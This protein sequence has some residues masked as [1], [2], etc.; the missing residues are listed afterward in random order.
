MSKINIYID[1]SGVFGPY[2]FHSQ[3]YIVTLVIHNPTDNISENIKYLNLKLDNENLNNLTIHTGP[4]IRR[5]YDYDRFTLLERKRIFNILYNFIRTIDIKYHTIL[6]EKKQLTSDIDLA[7][8][9]SKKLS[10]FLKENVQFFL[11]HESIV[12]YYDKGQ[13]ELNNVIVSVFNSVL[14]NVEFEKEKKSQVDQKLFQTADML[15]TL[16]LLAEK[17]RRK[18]LTKSELAFFSSG[19]KIYKSYLRAI[20]HKKLM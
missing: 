14:S 3:Y 4:L 8:R 10:K 13:K 16:E 1:E 17:I 20:E 18:S 11:N 2:Q 5:E 7:S 9:I 6:I 15:C 12:V 19:K